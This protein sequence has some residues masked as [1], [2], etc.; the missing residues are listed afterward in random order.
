MNKVKK[1]IVIANCSDC[2]KMGKCIAWKRLT[3]YKRAKLILDGETD[4]SVLS[5]CPLDDLTK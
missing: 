5:D 1:V 3:P 2:P 4:K